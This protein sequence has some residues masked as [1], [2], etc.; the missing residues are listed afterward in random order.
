MKKSK[1]FLLDTN[2][3]IELMCDN[4]NVAQRLLDVGFD[5]CRMSAISLHELNFGAFNANRKSEK[6]YLREMVRIKKLLEKIKVLSLPAEAAEYYG[7]IKYTLERQGKR[8][9]E[10]DMLIGGHA[11]ATGM[12]VVTDNIKHFEN[13]PD[14]DIENWNIRDK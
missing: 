6:L 7:K 12:T 5:N 10:F 9:D 2:I 14:V 4:P 1:Q 11:L 13:M 3:L 8:V